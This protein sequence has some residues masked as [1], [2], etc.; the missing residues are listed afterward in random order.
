MKNYRRQAK[1]NCLSKVQG[2]YIYLKENVKNI[3]CLSISILTFYALLMYYII[4][5]I[6]SYNINIIILRFRI[7]FKLQENLL[8][9]LNVFVFAITYTFRS[10]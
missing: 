1:I 4:G 5:T 7:V 2:F 6:Q 10:Y 3:N 8:C 9:E